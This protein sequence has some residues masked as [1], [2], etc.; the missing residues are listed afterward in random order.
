MHH[1]TTVEKL[2]LIKKNYAIEIK[3]IGL[4]ELALQYYFTKTNERKY[5]RNTVLCI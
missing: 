4:R 1:Y 5:H 2:L 3:Y